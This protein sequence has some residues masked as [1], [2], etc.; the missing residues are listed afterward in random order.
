MESIIE[1]HD[2]TS[3]VNIARKKLEAIIEKERIISVYEEQVFI[4]IS[5]DDFDYE[6]DD[7]YDDYIVPMPDTIREDIDSLG[8]INKKIKDE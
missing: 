5:E 8:I 3:L 7:I 4:Q 2:D 6:I 1:N